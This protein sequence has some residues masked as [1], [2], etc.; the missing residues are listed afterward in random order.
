[1]QTRDENEEKYQIW[2]YQLI[3]Y[4]ILQTNIMRII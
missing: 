3:R 4:Q 2:D 1:M